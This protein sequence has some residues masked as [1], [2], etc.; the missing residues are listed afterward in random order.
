[1][2]FITEELWHEMSPRREGQTIMYEHTPVAGPYDEAFLAQFALL[3]EAIVGVR[4]VRAQK[5]ISPKEAL[6]LYIEGELCQELKPVFLKSANLSEIR[7]GVC[8]QACVSFIVGTLKMS[9]PVGGLVDLE[10]ERNKILAELEHQRGFLAGVQKKLSNETF[11][12]HA[13]QAVVA[14]ER[15]KESDALSRI[16]A[17]EASLKAL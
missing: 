9:V 4:G 7:S 16:E 15:K 8:E 1:M 10:E 17:L 6:V 14:L 12:S 5:Q 11:I 13:P 2:P 3:Q